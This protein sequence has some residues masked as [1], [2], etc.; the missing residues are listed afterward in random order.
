MSERLELKGT[1]TGILAMIPPG[2]W[3]DAQAALMQAIDAKGEFLRGAEFTINVGSRELHASE[4]GGLRARLA[5]KEIQ[6]RFVR[7]DNT[8]TL[9]AAANLGLREPEKSRQADGETTAGEELEAHV[10]GDAG[11]FLHRT[12]R[13]G[14]RIHYGGHVVVLGDVNPGAEIVAAGNVIVWGRLRGT[15]HAGAGGNSSA[16][17]CALDLA[18]TQL[19]IAGQIAV[20]PERKGRSRPET[21]LIREG[22]LVAEPWSPDKRH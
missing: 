8:V 16:V 9:E 12:L 14:H 2:D 13:S 7:S 3:G 1:S 22:Q 15:V 17:V 20:S 5:E 18:P 6:L 4:L 11:L 21:A 19:R 10:D